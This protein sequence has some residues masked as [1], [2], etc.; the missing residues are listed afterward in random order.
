MTYHLGIDVGGTK[1]EAMIADGEGGVVGIGRAGP[2]NWEVVGYAGLTATL[3]EAT[4]KA[5]AMAHLPISRVATAGMGIAGLDWPC[6]RESHLDAIRPLGLPCL[7]VIVNDAA[8]GIPAGAE[9]GWGLS[10]VSGTSCN[11]RGWDR[12]RT[13]EGRAI[14]GG[15]MW[16]GEA[17]GGLDIVSRAM[18]AIAFEWTRRGPSTALTPAFM[19]RFAVRDPGELV[20]GAYLRRFR[21][22]QSLVTTVFAV[23]AQGDPEALRVIRWAG[24]QLGRMACGVIVQLD[25]QHESFDV[26]LIGSIYDGHPLVTEALGETVHGT[27]PRARIV[28]LTAPPVVGGVLLGMDAAAGR[29]GTPRARLLASCR[30]RCAAPLE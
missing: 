24:T 3:R 12:G 26:V 19:E 13:R 10:I 7:P 9:E 6:Q 11:C 14:G 1:T 15:N 18:R 22:D 8:L 23:A 2:G 16:T 4:G 28:R 30:D 20:E 29:A 17:A 21:L 27:A 5:L 25:F